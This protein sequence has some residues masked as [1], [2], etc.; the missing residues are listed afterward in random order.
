VH[1]LIFSEINGEVFE[2]IND[3]II[4]RPTLPCRG[5][6]GTL[7][8]CLLPNGGGHSQLQGRGR[9]GP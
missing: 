9:E 4:S 2:K 8:K 1:C 7:Q 3:K 6:S 5:V